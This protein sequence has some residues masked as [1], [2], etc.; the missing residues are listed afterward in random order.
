[1][2]FKDLD[3]VREYMLEEVELDIKNNNIYYSKFFN[4][5]GKQAYVELLKEAIKNGDSDM[6]ALRLAHGN[7]FLH[8]YQR[9]T[10]K[11]GVTYAQVPVTAPQTFAEGQFNRFFMRGV[12]RR[13]LAEAQGQVRV[14][15]AKQ[16][17]NPRPESQQLVGKTL[18]AN[19]LLNSLR[20]DENGFGPNSGLS[21]EIA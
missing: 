5:Y 3:L 7:Y 16:S 14:Y 12:C 8:E 11:G 13:S 4:A 6:L 20:S 1:M 18:A 9:N 2:L 15:R 17:E 19:E 10:P 21:A